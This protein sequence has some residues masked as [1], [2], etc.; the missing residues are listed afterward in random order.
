[1]SVWAALRTAGRQKTIRPC[2]PGSQVSKQLSDEPLGCDRLD[3]PPV[4]HRLDGEAA[5]TAT[6]D[7]QDAPSPDPKALHRDLREATGP[8]QLEVAPA[9]LGKALAVER[10]DNPPA[11]GRSEP[12]AHGPG[13]LPPLPQDTRLQV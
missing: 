3:R 2:E 6:G 8:T 9:V 11:A 1:M 7:R 12:P 13:A 10:P 4:T 5:S